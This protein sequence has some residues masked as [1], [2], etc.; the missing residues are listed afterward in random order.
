MRGISLRCGIRWALVASALL[1]AAPSSAQQSSS[2][3]GLAA[4]AV[5]PVGRYADTKNPGY[6]LGL[7]LNLG[8][9]LPHLDVRVDGAFAELKYKGSSTKEQ[10]WLLDANLVARGPDVARSAPYL[11]GGLG[12]YNRRRTL[13]LGSNASS[14]VGLNGGAGIRFRAGSGYVFVESRYHAALGSSDLRIVPVTI[15]VSF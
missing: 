7:A 3:L 6:H 2:S 1:R 9:A 10:I 13:L 15:G 4:G 8:T 12:F 11:I 14:H 5:V